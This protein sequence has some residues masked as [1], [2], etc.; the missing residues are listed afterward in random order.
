MR[1]TNCRKERKTKKGLCKL[2]RP[3]DCEKNKNKN[4]SH[5]IDFD[6]TDM[7]DTTSTRSIERSDDHSGES[8]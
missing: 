4:S 8:E 1:C 6:F 3:D 5:L 7:R 2:C